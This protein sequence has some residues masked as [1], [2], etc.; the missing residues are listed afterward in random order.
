MRLRWSVFVLALAVGALPAVAQAAHGKQGAPLTVYAGPN[1]ASPPAGIKQADALTFFPSQVTIRVGQTVTWQF[2]G[3]HTVTFAGT[4]KNPPFIVAQPGS[5]QPTVNDAA[6]RPF[7]WSG[8]APQLLLDPFALLPQGGGTLSSPA[9]VAS[10]GLLRVITA[11]AKTAPKPYSLRFTRPGIYHYVCLVHPGMRG[12]VRVLGKRAKPATPAAIAK[13]AN[14]QLENVVGDL[15][16][17]A[18]TK[19]AQPLSVS[20]GAGARSG[21]E[22][23]SFFPEQLTVHVGDTV[24]FVQ[25]DPTDIHTVTFGPESYTLPIEQNLFQQLGSPPQPFFNPLAALPSEPPPPSPVSYDGTNHGNGFV[26]SGVLDPPGSPKGPGQFVVT[27]TKAGT[28]RYEC[29]I[30]PDMDGTI[31]VQQ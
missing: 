19:P 22:I 1:V 26:T 31:V 27:F 7:W 24:T 20:V 10:S 15:R 8:T 2:R 3:F 29:V 16:Q 23:T 30:H 5:P 13:L 14:A 25:N 11:P 18:T 28:Y 6:G 4:M 9:T 17:L 21:A 12:T